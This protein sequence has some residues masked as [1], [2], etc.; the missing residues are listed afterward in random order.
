MF[1]LSG[2]H[3]GGSRPD[4][5]AAA[6]GRTEPESS[7]YEEVGSNRGD[8][9]KTY[10][11]GEDDYESDESLDGLVDDLPE[12]GKVLYNTITSLV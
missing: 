7:I 6:E 5:P 2:I 8:H 12:L 4:H 11:T 1:N 3:Q 10:D 9:R